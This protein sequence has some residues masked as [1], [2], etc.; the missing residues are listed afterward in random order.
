E[1]GLTL[2][3]PIISAGSFGLSCDYKEKLTRLLPPA[4]KISEFFVHFWHKEFKNLKPKWKTAY[5]YKKVNN[6]EECFWYINAL[7][8]PSALDAEKPN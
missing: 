4:R 1:V 2:T 3:I 6:T 8:A 5:I 7:E